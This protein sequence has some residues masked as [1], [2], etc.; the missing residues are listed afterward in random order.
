MNMSGSY[1]EVLLPR[2]MLLESVSAILFVSGMI[3]PSHMWS[4]WH[5]PFQCCYPRFLQD[6]LD[7]PSMF[8]PGWDVV[9]VVLVQYGG[10][11]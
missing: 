8:D 3:V 7:A 6:G 9:E 2:T 4:E 10:S 5:F 11:D 1:E